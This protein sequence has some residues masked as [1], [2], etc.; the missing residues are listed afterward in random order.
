M[1]NPTT[2]N[3]STAA[4]G[5]DAR[6]GVRRRVYRA[7][8]GHLWCD[9]CGNSYEGDRCD[10]CAQKRPR[11]GGIEGPVETFGGALVWVQMERD[12]D[13]D[14]GGWRCSRAFSSRTAAAA[15]RTS[16]RR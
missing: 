13:D 7:V 10:Y 12:P 5:D 15:V 2:S 9:E 16:A 3:G 14:D 11:R 4:A 6:L 8:M 1:T